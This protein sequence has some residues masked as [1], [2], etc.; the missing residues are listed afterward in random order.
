MSKYLDDNGLLYF[1][2]KIKMTFVQSENGKGLSSN[3]YTTTEKNKLSGIEAGAQVNVKP[4]WNASSGSSA[5]IL[6]KPSNLSDFTNDEGFVT[7]TDL[8]DYAPLA[9]P[10]LTGTPT[11]PTPTS[12][13]D[14]NQ[15]ANTEFVNDA[16]ANAISGITG[17]SFEI[18]QTLPATGDAGKIYLLSNSGTSPN[19]Y[20]EYIYINNSWEKIGTTDVDL[21]GYWSKAELVTITNSEIMILRFPPAPKRL[22]SRIL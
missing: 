19:I 1:W 16:I 18:V 17:I 14:N 4:D 11:T 21:T 9:S 6:N 12:G 5:E 7:S 20:D 3:D 22:K 10:A 2:Q 15:I 8:D 13:A